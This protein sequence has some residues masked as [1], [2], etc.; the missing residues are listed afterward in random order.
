MSITIAYTCQSCGATQ[1]V[2]P[3][4]HAASL[5]KCV[6]CSREH[7]SLYEVRQELCQVARESAT[8]RAQQ[9]LRTVRR[10]RA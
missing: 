10:H 7:G 8:E 3:Q 5:V 2:L 1:A 4:P 6:G 9:V